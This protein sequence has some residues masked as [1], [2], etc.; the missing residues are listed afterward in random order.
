MS[1][2][3]ELVAVERHDHA[4][5]AQERPRGTIESVMTRSYATLHATQ[6]QNEPSYYI[7]LSRFRIVRQTAVARKTTK[8]LIA[9]GRE[10]CLYHDWLISKITVQLLAPKQGVM[11]WV[12]LH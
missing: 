4:R 7:Q 10:I 9:T 12:T 1:R 11:R 8:S 5:I 3:L 6:T 2:S